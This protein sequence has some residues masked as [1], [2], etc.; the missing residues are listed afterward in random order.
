MIVMLSPSPALALLLSK[1]L[2]HTMRGR[3]RRWSN[4]ISK[5]FNNGNSFMLSGMSMEESV[6]IARGQL[7][8]I[9]LSASFFT[10]TNS[11]LL[12]MRFVYFSFPVFHSLA[13][14]SLRTSIFVTIPREKNFSLPLKLNYV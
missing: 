10:H 8:M 6:D 9:S 7:M 1:E 14:S 11:I 13:L 4:L 3:G 5:S 12:K 2:C